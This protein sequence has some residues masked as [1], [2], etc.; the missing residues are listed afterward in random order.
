[1]FFKSSER[2][3]NHLQICTTICTFDAMTGRPRRAAAVEAMASMK[4]TGDDDESPPVGG[5][6]SLRAR[7][8]SARVDE[9][10]DPEDDE[11]GHFVRRSSRAAKP[12]VARL[13]PDWKEDDDDLDEPTSDG[14]GEYEDGS[15]TSEPD[16]DD[17]DGAEPTRYSKRE[18]VTIQRYSPP[19]PASPRRDGSDEEKQGGQGSRGRPASGKQAGHRPAG[20]FKRDKRDKNE[21]R[22]RNNNNRGGARGHRWMDDTDDSD[23]DGETDA[24]GGAPSLAGGQ[25]PWGGGNNGGNPYPLAPQGGTYGGDL[26]GGG[27]GG[28]G[29]GGGNGAGNAAGAEITPLQVDPSLTFAEVGGL[30]HYVHSLKEMVFLPL[31]YPEVFARFKMA[32]PRGVLLYG[33]PGTG[34]VRVGSCAHLSQF[35]GSLCSHNRPAKGRLLPLPI[36]RP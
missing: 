14:E 36:V 7:G 17:E 13:S 31:L 28:A 3:V 4:Q 24:F 1:M 12:V 25:H 9:D 5:R 29:A 34:K 33:A 19:K 16:P 26:G 30:S 15:E 35:P 6:K 32:P 27:G 23:L 18:R 11:E 8:R 2:S 10:S 21:A 20:G 22:D